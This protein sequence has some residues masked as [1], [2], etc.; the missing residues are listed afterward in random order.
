MYA[1][2]LISGAVIAVVGVLTASSGVPVL[3]HEFDPSVI[4][5]GASLV[6]SG[7]ILVAW[8]STLRLARR[9][10]YRIEHALTAPPLPLPSIPEEASNAASAVA[11]EP[12]VAP[13]PPPPPPPMRISLPP[14]P[15]IR[16]Q[17]TPATAAAALPEDAALA[18]L[19]EQFPVLGPVETAT[20]VETTDISLPA[21]VED[22]VESD[23]VVALARGQANGAAPVRI[24]PRLDPRARPT[25]GVERTR[26][27][28]AYWPK[29]QRPVPGAPPAPAV[30]PAA[31]VVPPPP[32][33]IQPV[34]P[35]LPAEPTQFQFSETP[36]ETHSEARTN[37][38]AQVYVLKSGVVDGMAYT[39]Y[40]DGSIEAQLPQG[41]LRFG[42]IAELRNHIEQSA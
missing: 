40:S 3:G 23:N 31:S 36:P 15:E 21:P 27:F 10:L 26:K 12:V 42:S 30:Q 9:M 5:T 2:L 17:P 29:K 18:R 32:P 16:P 20:V 37:G 8:A 25:P 34:A 4:T 19:R 13:P 11:A 38:S 1:F 35:A 41:M 24:E 22:V 28:D 33:A 6:A 39:L 14:E 7:L